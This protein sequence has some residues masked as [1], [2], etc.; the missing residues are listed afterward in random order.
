MT[1]IDVAPPEG[2]KYELEFLFTAR[3]PAGE[4]TT[5]NVRQNFAD[6]KVYTLDTWHELVSAPAASAGQSSTAAG[7]WEI[8]HSHTSSRPRRP[9]GGN[10]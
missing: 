7:S 10:D 9:A 2:A 4:Q 6:G 1:A 5:W 3:N 8:R